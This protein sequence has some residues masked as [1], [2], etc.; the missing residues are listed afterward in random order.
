MTPV[1]ENTLEL[2][3]Q[4]VLVRRAGTDAVPVL[5]LHGA[6]TSSADWTGLLKRTGGIAPDLPGFGRSGK[7]GDLDFS[8]GG[9][10]R[11]VGDL[12][13]LLELDRVRLC[14]HGWGAVGL[15]WAIENPARVER[16]LVVNAVPFLPGFRWHG[17]ARALSLPALGEVAVGVMTRRVWRRSVRRTSAPGS[18][19]ADGLSRRIDADFDQ[20]TQRALLRLQRHAAPAALARLGSDLDRIDAPALVLW[21]AHDRW[22]DPRFG[23]AYAAALGDATHEQLLD[24]GHWP[25]LDSEVAANRMVSFLT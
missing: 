25:W 2:A 6:P 15:L 17:W 10:A 4:P 13:D 16:L 1:V 23:P 5:Y 24:A 7:R 12:V 22:I 9:L 14:V 20:G 21:G 19:I 8:P 18:R 11:F 3:G